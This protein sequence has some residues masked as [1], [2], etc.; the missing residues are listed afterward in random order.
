[1]YQVADS[2]SESDS[3]ELFDIIISEKEIIPDTPSG[4]KKVFDNWL[5]EGYLRLFLK[6]SE[7]QVSDYSGKMHE[8]DYK[9]LVEWSSFRSNLNSILKL[10][11]NQSIIFENNKLLNVLENTNNKPIRLLNI[12]KETN[13]KSNSYFESYRFLQKKSFSYSD[14]NHSVYHFRDAFKIIGE[15]YFSGVL[16][17]KIFFTSGFGSLGI[18]QVLGAYLNGSTVLIAE[19]DEKLL[20]KRVQLGFCD[21]IYYDAKTAIEVVQDAKRNYMPKIIG[22]CTSSTNVLNEFV[23]MGITPNIITDATSDTIDDYIPDDYSLESLKRLKNTDPEYYNSILKHTIKNN[24]RL[25]LELK[26]RGSLIFESGNN[27]KQ[28]ADNFNVENTQIVSNLLEENLYRV[29]MNKENIDFSIIPLSFNSE[30]LFIIDDV[31]NT[32]FYYLDTSDYKDYISL[33]NKIIHDKFM[34]SKS[35]RENKLSVKELLIELNELVSNYEISQPLLISIPRFEIS[36]VDTDIN[37]SGYEIEKYISS[38]F[39]D[40]PSINFYGLQKLENEKI[41]KYT[42]NTFLLDGSQKSLDKI[43]TL[44]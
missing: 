31:I 23:N 13:I 40:I 8:Y 19:P 6:N 35:F 12:F 5:Q 2:E 37:A 38:D 11:N 25:K 30:D 21:T 44:I 1:L 16:E 43:L 17:G 33:S 10:K 28:R 26:K 14:L 20:R 32:K 27:F 29:I 3:S 34:F 22:V 4:N 39:N 7:L 9:K 18:S 24:I 36:D 15:E 42:E 41:N